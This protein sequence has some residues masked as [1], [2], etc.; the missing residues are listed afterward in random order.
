MGTRHIRFSAWVIRWKKKRNLWPR[1]VYLRDIA[2]IEQAAFLSDPAKIGGAKYYLQ[3]SI[4][5]CLDLGN[6]IIAAEHYRLPK[7]YRDIF[8]VLSE[9]KV[10][11]DDFALTLRR[12]AGL[13]NRLVHLYWEVD[14]RNNWHRPP[15]GLQSKHGYKRRADPH[16]I[17]RPGTE[18]DRPPDR[19][20]LRA[21]QDHLVRLV[22]LRHARLGQRF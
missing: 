9:N 4:A 21:G 22:C 12:M 11:P 8:T 20:G 1:A 19:G 6:H 18:A 17:A 10:I 7:D 14:E 15:F 3:T 16:P 13:R 2:Q 5:A